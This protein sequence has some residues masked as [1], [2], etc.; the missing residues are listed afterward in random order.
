MIRITVFPRGELIARPGSKRP[1]CMFIIGKGSGRNVLFHREKFEKSLNQDVR[2]VGRHAVV[3]ELGGT[4]GAGAKK[5]ELVIKIQVSGLAA[6]LI[7]QVMD[8]ARGINQGNRSAFGADEIVATSL[9]QNK[10]EVSRSL[11]ES[12]PADNTGIS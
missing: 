2:F 6:Y 9:G 12:E 4:L 3:R 7:L 5:F 10:C 11:V 1:Q 8:R